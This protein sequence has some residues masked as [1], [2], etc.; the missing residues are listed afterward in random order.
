MLPARAP[1]R[2]APSLPTRAAF[3]LIELLVVVIIVAILA[4]LLLPALGQARARARQVA[5]KN[6]LR[7]IGLACLAYADAWNGV[8]PPFR[9]SDKIPDAPSPSHPG[10][11]TLEMGGE[12]IHVSRPRWNIVIGPFIEGSIDT[13]QWDPD[14]DGYADKGT[15]P[16]TDDDY[17]TFQN[18]VFICPDADGLNTS[19]NAAYGYNYQFLGNTRHFRD[20]SVDSRLPL[21]HPGYGP[22]WVNFPVTVARIKVT[23]RTVMVADSLG[24]ASG[25]PADLRQPFVSVM[26][27][28][29]A[30]GNHGYA[31]DPPFP[32]FVND[33][34]LL[35]LGAVSS[36]DCNP[37]Y[38]GVDPR[39]VG[40]TANIVFVDGH[41]ASMT[42]EALGYVVREDGSYAFQNIRELLTPDAPTTFDPR[43]IRRNHL[44]ATNEWFS[45]VGVHRWVPKQWRRLP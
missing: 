6:N 29:E 39:H 36:G 24:T 34:G 1:A 43:A 42:P 10:Y 38:S 32:W 31:L 35:E 23:T 25:L 13:K 2:R 8:F 37:G 9:W 41:V 28:C 22:P 4:G 18:P 21:G 19:R 33:N 30:I 17:T 20:P 15:I 11:V 45:G 16:G 27:R 26:N 5:C 40:G 7:Q 3:T 12:R 44:R 14:G